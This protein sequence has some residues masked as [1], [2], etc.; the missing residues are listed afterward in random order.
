MVP[1]WVM[2]T[3]T[4]DKKIIIIIML[5]RLVGAAVYDLTFFSSLQHTTT[6][7]DTS[8][9][10]S[11]VNKTHCLMDEEKLEHTSYYF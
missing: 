1:F 8:L 10:L 6:R 7:T 5:L 9:C 2:K 4:G 3:H 11:L